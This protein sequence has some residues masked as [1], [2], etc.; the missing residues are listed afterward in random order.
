MTS[1]ISLTA[2]SDSRKQNPV[3]D[4]LGSHPHLAV[5][6]DLS[7]GER[8]GICIRSGAQPF[9]EGLSRLSFPFFFSG[10]AEVCE[11]SD[12]DEEEFKIQVHLTSRTWGRLFGHRGSLDATWQKVELEKIPD[13]IKPE[14]EERCQDFD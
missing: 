2:V 6:L 8:G 5:D 3:V 13:H 7:V 11:W 4:H 12:E 14:R 1:Q 10:I 9:Y